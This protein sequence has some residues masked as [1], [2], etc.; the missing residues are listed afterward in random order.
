[1]RIEATQ[2]VAAEEKELSLIGTSRAQRRVALS[3]GALKSYLSATLRRVH[4]ELFAE[5]TRALQRIDLTPGQFTILVVIDENTCVKQIEIATAIGIKKANLAPTIALLENRGLITR[6]VA[7]IDGR[8]HYLAI[9]PR[10]KALLALA[11][12]AVEAIESRVSEILGSNEAKANLIQH[13]RAI[14]GAFP[15]RGRTLTVRR[16]KAQ[17]WKESNRPVVSP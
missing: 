13:L 14:G 4:C 17:A 7:A 11:R 15:D 8:F 16:M 9:T 3:L 5:V 2:P 1:M 12:C 6:N 10:G